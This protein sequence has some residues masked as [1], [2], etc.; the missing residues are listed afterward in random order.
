MLVKL[1][2][3]RPVSTAE[4]ERTFSC[5]RRRK[6]G[7]RSTMTQERLNGVVLGHVHQS[8]VELFK[9]ADNFQKNDSCVATFGKLGE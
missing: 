9:I 8:L 4:C 2:L 5:P 6:T 7:R 3:L 1:L